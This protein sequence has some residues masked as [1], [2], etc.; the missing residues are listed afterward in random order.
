MKPKISVIIPVYKVEKYLDH[1]VRSVLSQTMRDIEVILVDDESPD[2]CPAMCDAYAAGDPR[3][4]AIHQKN[5]GLGGARNAGLESARGEYVFFLDSDDWIDPDGLR[6]MHERAASARVD[7]V[8]TGETLFIDGEERYEKGYRDYSG[9]GKKVE[10]LRA[11]NMIE[12]FTP[13]WS[14]LYRADFIAK[15]NLR[16]VEKCYYE[17]NSWGCLVFLFA[18]RVAFAPNVMFYR[19]RG[20]SISGRVDRRVFD[21][22]KD[23]EFLGLF[24]KRRGVENPKSRFVFIWYLRAYFNYLTSFPRRGDRSDFYDEAG[25]SLA[26][27]KIRL[28]D[29]LRVTGFAK[30]ATVL[31]LWH[32]Y[33]CLR[34][35]YGYDRYASSI[36]AYLFGV[37]PLPRTRSK[38]GVSK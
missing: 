21:W 37:I 14:R 28:R 7:V 24:M 23:C 27:I 26:G 6:V 8:V 32:L 29:I 31:E 15:N 34:R 19:R 18:D 1:C 4:R 20:D 13:A 35:G 9:K 36:G 22:M 38:Q 30:V 16:F 17:D 25:K 11:G 5:R 12:T 3:V 10:R 2:S 33:R